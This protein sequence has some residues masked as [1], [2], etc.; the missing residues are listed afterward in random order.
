MS[1]TVAWNIAKGVQKVVLMNQ[2]LKEQLETTE[3]VS[4][5]G[6][7]VRVLCCVVC[8]CDV[9]ACVVLCVCVM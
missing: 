5:A 2:E 4:A 7:F 6:V 8:L 9:S 1:S 3:I